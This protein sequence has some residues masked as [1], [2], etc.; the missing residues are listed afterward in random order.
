MSSDKENEERLKLIL[1]I[2]QKGSGLIPDDERWRAIEQRLARAARHG[3]PPWR[4]PNRYVL[5][6]SEGDSKGDLK[7]ETEK[8]IRHAVS[9]CPDIAEE[10]VTL[11]NSQPQLTK[12]YWFLRIL[13]IAS[14]AEYGMEIP[15][16]T[17][18][19]L[20]LLM[21]RYPALANALQQREGLTSEVPS[22]ENTA[23]ESEAGMTLVEVH[24]RLAEISAY[25]VENFHAYLCITFRNNLLKAVNHDDTNLSVDEYEETE[26]ARK[27]RKRKKQSLDKLASES[28]KK[29]DAKLKK[30]SPPSPEEALIASGSYLLESIPA[31]RLR[32]VAILR[33]V[34]DLTQPEVAKEL[35][36]TERTVRAD[37]EKIKALLRKQLTP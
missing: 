30:V 28:E 11:I 27:L 13:E 24:K 17:R 1:E 7:Q 18:R 5:R 4:D 37:E 16:I 20:N 8:L 6:E 36:V 14:F 31:G 21:T 22:V 32:K 9:W 25:A 3:R 10:I 35:N 2:A 29:L 23:V 33:Y 15:R 12:I 34:E 26:W 19:Y